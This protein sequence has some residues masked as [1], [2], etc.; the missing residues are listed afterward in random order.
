MT[1]VTDSANIVRYKVLSYKRF[2]QQMATKIQATSDHVA[3]DHAS[4]VSE[5]VTST[6]MTLGMM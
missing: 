3:M 2:S 5:R 1:H 6:Q 4:R